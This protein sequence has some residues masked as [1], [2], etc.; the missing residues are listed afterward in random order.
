MSFLR[1]L[2]AKKTV[3][4]TE[5]FIFVDMHS[6]L[7]PAIDDGS[8]SVEESV[9]LVKGLIDLGYKKIITTPHIMGD[10]FKNSKETIFPGLKILQDKLIEEGIDIKIE[11]AAEYY[12]DEWFIEK[13]DKEE[14]L[15]S[16]G[17]N[18]VLFETSYMNASSQLHQAIF[19][20]RSIGYTP[21]LAHPERYTY[22]YGGGFDGFKEIY[23][24]GVLFQINLNSLAGY[25]SK[26]AKV[27]AEKLIDH[28]MVDFVGTDC[29]GQRHLDVL[30]K[31]KTSSYYKKLN[32]LPLL[33][34]SLLS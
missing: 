2:F 21:I 3:G 22:L 15:L 25:Y 4:P 20:L 6:H 18:Y 27:F 24:M 10:F 17:K 23:D 19:K 12:L 13:L 26:P 33:N 30:R 29:H 14:P 1:N 9:S 34:N 31:L 28:K 7:I 16:F 32:D 11:A 8:K 5:D